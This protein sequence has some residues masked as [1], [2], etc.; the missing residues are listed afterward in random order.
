MAQN[1]KYSEPWVLNAVQGFTLSLIGRLNA[2]DA[3]ALRAQFASDFPRREML[4]VQEQVY[5]KLKQV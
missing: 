2:E 4:P 1:A 5:E 3:D